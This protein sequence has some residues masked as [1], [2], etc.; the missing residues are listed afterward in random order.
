[1]LYKSEDIWLNK[2]TMKI[3]ALLTDFGLR[4]NF[5]GTMKAVILNINDKANIIDLSHDVERQDIFGAAFLLRSSYR[6][7]PK[8]SIFLTVIDPGVG[9]ERNALIV[10]TRNYFFVGPDNGVLSLAVF[11][12]GLMKAVKISNKKY[13]L[14]DISDTFHGRDIFAPASAYLSKGMALASF[15]RSLKEIKRLHVQEPEAAGNILKGEV[16]YIDRFGN[17]ITN[18]DKRHFLLFTGNKKFEIQ[19]R[20]RKIVSLSKAYQHAGEGELLA[21]FG[22]SGYLEISVNGA[23]AREYFMANKGEEVRVIII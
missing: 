10:K 22:S 11:E 19:L 3:V 2:G 9:T 20:D 16:I 17:L 4:D 14:K 18:I 5:V 6:Y 12:D 7:F 23:S 13:M 1:M 15:G 21:I 8:G